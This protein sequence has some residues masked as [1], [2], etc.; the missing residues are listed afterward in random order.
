M[1][2]IEYSR[3]WTKTYLEPNLIEIF[4]AEEGASSL[5]FRRPWLH[6]FLSEIAEIFFVAAF[7]NYLLIARFKG[8]RYLA[9][10]LLGLEVLFRL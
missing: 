9:G 5:T 3:F 7:I 10:K 4:A 1:V 2:R 8:S 6:H